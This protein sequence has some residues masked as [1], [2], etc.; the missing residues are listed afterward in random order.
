MAQT[1]TDQVDDSG[2][3][4]CV[5]IGAVLVLEAAG[6]FDESASIWGKKRVEFFKLFSFLMEDRFLELHLLNSM[7]EHL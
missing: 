4:N 1:S 2:K 3:L 5:I 6:Q 7:D